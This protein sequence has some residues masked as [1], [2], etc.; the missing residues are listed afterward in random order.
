VGP[1]ASLDSGKSRPTGIRSPELPA[2]SQSLYRLS[3]LAHMYEGTVRNA[4]VQKSPTECGGHECDREASIMRRSR[5]TR[6][7]FAGGGGVRFGRF[8]FTTRGNFS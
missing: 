8:L 1:R 5:P 6:D 2:L 7:C 3:Y 4:L